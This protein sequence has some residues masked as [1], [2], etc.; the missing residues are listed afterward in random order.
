MA[1]KKTTDKTVKKTP[2]KKTATKSVTPKTKPTA[3]KADFKPLPFSTP[4]ETATVVMPN[5]Q[6]IKKKEVQMLGAMLELELK[7]RKGNGE[8]AESITQ[9]LLGSKKKGVNLTDELTNFIIKNV[10]IG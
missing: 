10:L 9:R 1:T 4:N 8:S 3:K 6:T 2:A 7:G 5:G